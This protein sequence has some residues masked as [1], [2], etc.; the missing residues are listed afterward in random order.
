MDSEIGRI[1]EEL[2]GRKMFKFIRTKRSQHCW[3]QYL[4]F[5]LLA[6]L[7]PANPPPPLPPHSLY[8]PVHLSSEGLKIYPLHKVSFQGSLN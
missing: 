2:G 4:L 7:P 3:T 5:H 6:F 1:W 8:S